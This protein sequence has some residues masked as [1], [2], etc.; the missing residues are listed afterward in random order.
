MGVCVCVCVCVGGGGF[1]QVHHV[2][3]LFKV[4]MH[5]HN[6]SLAHSSVHKVLTL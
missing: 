5:H 6:M 4:R 3:R 1:C 2:R